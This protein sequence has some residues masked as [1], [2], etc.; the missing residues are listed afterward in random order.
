MQLYDDIAESDAALSSHPDTTLIRA[1]RDRGYPSNEIVYLSLGETWDS[2]APGLV[3]CLRTAVP[4][5]AHGY[6]LSPY[7]LPALRHRLHEMVTREHELARHEGRYT[8]AVSQAGTRGTMADFAR[9]LRRLPDRGSPA[10]TP[11]ALIPSPGWDYASLLAAQGYR[12]LGYPIIDE[13]GRFGPDIES[14]IDLLRSTTAH[15]PVLLVV[16][17]QHNPT[18]WDWGPDRVTA[19][20][21]AA[22]SHRANVVI[23]DAYYSVHD[24][25]RQPTNA[26][27]T[28]L[29]T[30]EDNT[31][32]LAVRSLGKQYQA[33][34]WGIGSMVGPPATVD[35]LVE[36][37]T[38]R[39]YGS[40]IP[41]QAAMSD[42]IENHESQLHTEE[43]RGTIA[44]HRLHAATRLAELLPGED[45]V[46]PGDC[47][48][49]MR[50][51]VPTR[52]VPESAAAAQLIR[53]RFV[54]ELAMR[55]GVVLGR[56]SM[57]DAV[58]AET[59][60]ASRT[61]WVRM[62]IGVPRHVLDEGLERIAGFLEGWNPSGGD[63]DVRG[64]YSRTIE[65]PT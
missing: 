27:L 50:V 25:H 1:L 40:A 36:S 22:C 7:G 16:N 12:V 42:W 20:L 64:T 11:V 60:G 53:D 38:T 58:D 65:S 2:V 17:A 9:L 28:Q 41:L 62:H 10:G 30:A 49:Y 24:P 51:A 52:E 4:R 32:W 6:T 48:T 45:I 57:T 33:N 18:G 8:V 23:D 29:D 46:S 5:F 19:L 3:D 61:A 14:A 13:G 21:R 15:S 31:H 59:P 47:T 39:S 35:R 34:G 26:L 43:F 56:G 63:R 54:R 37:T 44:A 55:T